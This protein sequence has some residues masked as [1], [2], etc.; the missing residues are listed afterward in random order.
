MPRQH[1]ALV[2][3][4]LL[5]FAYAVANHAANSI[6]ILNERRRAFVVLGINF[7]VIACRIFISTLPLLRHG[8][9][10]LRN[11]LCNC[12][13]LCGPFR[14]QLAIVHHHLLIL[15][16]LMLGSGKQFLVRLFCG[17]LKIIISL[18]LRQFVHQNIYRLRVVFGGGACGPFLHLVVFA[19]LCRVRLLDLGLL[20]LR[21]F[22]GLQ[23][24]EANER[25]GSD[26][27]LV[28]PER[29]SLLAGT[30]L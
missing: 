16:S 19:T 3:L 22:G 2:A 27:V 5:S 17:A 28:L 24:L 21:L 12:L 10:C 13:N 8:D 15:L 9:N 30:V 6:Q 11:L 4:K 25:L 26:H 18:I 1:R 14:A 7:V 23:G 20:L 29:L